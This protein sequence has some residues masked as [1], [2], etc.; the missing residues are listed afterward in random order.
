MVKTLI[1]RHRGGGTAR[2][3]DREKPGVRLLGEGGRL[4]LRCSGSWTTRR[5]SAVERPLSRLRGDETV[6]GQTAL[7]V[8]LGAVSELDTAGGLFLTH[9]IHAFRKAGLEVYLR[10]ATDEQVK[11]LEAVAANFCFAEPSPPESTP[12]VNLLN[13]IGKAQFKVVGD[14]GLLLSFLGQTVIALGAGI[15]RPWR[16]R[17]KAIFNVMETSGVNAL[18]IVGLISFLIGIVLAYQGAAQL[19]QFGAEVFTV[20]IV[21]VGVLREMAILLTAIIVAGRS[22]SA[23]TAQIGSMHVNEELDALRTL[24]MDPMDVLVIPRVLGLMLVLP[25]LTFYADMMGLLGGAIMTY[26]VL[27]ITFAQFIRQLHGAVDFWDLFA[28]LVKAPPFAFLIALVGCFEGFRVSRNAA[29][30]GH[31]TTRAV[32]EGVFLVIVLDAMLSIFFQI[33]GI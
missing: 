3:G 7:E 12:F 14:A 28:G 21:A 31:A 5:L 1:G 15:A 17:W 30:V 32:V 11:L 10:D 20:N 8:D 26:V 4:V 27:D 19:Q 25:L 2:A 29:S 6:K 22:G 13:R 9:T 23:Y 33:I 24:G 18:P 16:L